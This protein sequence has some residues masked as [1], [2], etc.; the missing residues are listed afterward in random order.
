MIDW[1]KEQWKRI[2][3]LI[4]FL[5]SLLT[6]LVYGDIIRGWIFPRSDEVKLG[7][8]L[9][10]CLGTPYQFPQTY[11]KSG[12]T[13][14][15]F[16]QKAQGHARLGIHNI[17]NVDEPDITIYVPAEAIIEVWT[18]DN[19]IRSYGPA[20]VFPLGNLPRGDAMTVFIWINRPFLVTDSIT[21]ASRYATHQFKA[22][23]LAALDELEY[24]RKGHY[25][26]GSLTVILSVTLL[27]FA[28][29]VF[30]RKNPPKTRR[31]YQRKP[32]AS[33][34]ENIS[35]ASSPS[36]PEPL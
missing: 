5:A 36:Q 10:D 4:L 32:Q 26:F 2:A 15:Q 8:I 33:T 30:R 31:R 22:S 29:W 25:I 27:L 1:L 24:Y 7:N 16:F 20:Q 17:S 34:S 21:Y 13:L 28:T 35:S 11:V 12:E 6:V 14:Q 3:T 19:L 9:L 18:K 23:D